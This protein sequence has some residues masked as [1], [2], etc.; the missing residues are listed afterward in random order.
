[1]DSNNFPDNIGVGEREGR[2][3]SG[4]VMERHFGFSHGIGRSGD[5]M[6]VQPKAAGSS[7]VVQLTKLKALKFFGV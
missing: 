6:A 7:L 2:V 3:Y 5:V 4:I 1:M